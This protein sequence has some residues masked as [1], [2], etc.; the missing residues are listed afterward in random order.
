VAGPRSQRPGGRLTPERRRLLDRLLDRALDLPDDERAAFLARCRQRA[1]RLAA[2]LDRLLIA[3]T[4]PTGFIDRSA[5][6][7]A[8]EALASKVADSG[9]GESLDPGTRL[10]AWR[11][12]EAVGS[13]G[14]GE[15]YRAERAD[16]AFEMVAAVKLIRGPSDDLARLLTTERQTLARL[17]HPG[18]ARLLDGGVSEDGRPWLAMDWVD[19][20]TLDSW[21]AT[22][23]STVEACLRV[24]GEACEA[25][26]A[27]HR[28]LIVHGDIK[29][30]NIKVTGEGRVCLLDFGVARLL[31]RDNQ[32]DA[33][34]ALTPGYAAPE[35]LEGRPVST[36]A[37][38]YGL[39]A[40]L[41][42]MVHGS[43][44]GH[45]EAIEARAAFAGYR[46][47][48][49]IRAI[50]GRARQDDPALR[51]PT[52]E[53]M[54]L[55]VARLRCDLP[56]RARRPRLFERAGLWVRRH[57]VGAAFGAL[58]VV[59]LIVGVTG[60][61]WQARVAAIE[62]DLA[63]A[64][65][66]RSNAL[67]E[68]LTLLFREVG[69]LAE[70]GDE[71]TARELL[72]QTARV[73]DEWLADDPQLRLQIEAV[74]AEI[75]IAL[76][77]WA[78]A[79]A[80][81]ADFA[82]QDLGDNPVLRSIALLDMAQ[83]QHR[84][85][86]V[87]EGLRLAERA[88]GELDSLPGTHPARLSDA[89]QVRGRLRRDAGDWDGAVADLRRAREMALEVSSGPRPLMARAENNLATTLLIG[90]D[91]AGAARHLEAAEALWLA[92]ER[93]ES[94][95]AL[96]VT[97]NLAS[98]LDRLGRVEEAER[99]LRR[100]V[101]VR[102]ERFGPSGAMGAAR[103]ALGRI[104]VVRGQ[105]DEAERHLG[106]AAEIFARFSGEDTPD[107]AASLLGLGEFHEARGDHAV[108]L[109]HFRRSREIMTGLLGPRHPYSLR[110]RLASLRVARQL[111]D[112]VEPEGIAE[113]AADVEAAGGAA[114]SMAASLQCEMARMDVERGRPE[115]A[116]EAANRCLD[117]RRALELGGWRETE[118]AALAALAGRLASGASSDAAEAVEQLGEQMYPGHPRVRWFERWIEQRT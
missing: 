6:D 89:L 66:A 2:W 73:A 87:D 17:N 9:P 24:F 53:A 101:E 75:M 97:A 65:A 33:A 50:I 25:V 54:A 23:A 94:S 95:D 88:V 110:T 28:E 43:A 38:I 47:L 58:A 30:A 40:L 77:D 76:S 48:R 59:L 1:P 34:L 31:D 106:R 20:Q 113:L 90:G 26:A 98:V 84:K 52:V 32:N 102:E 42:W 19:G 103:L 114:R 99:R 80:L 117:I 71:L 10:G 45:N 74:L 14:M 115:A 56:I 18:I 29:P 64:E 111:E 39:G 5:S 12:V 46:R 112:E 91:L 109:D 35:L 78:S 37:D 83:V 13:G 8:G 49:D 92:L 63:Q 36:A 7:L 55:D 72:D 60:V 81:L 86:R 62:R 15:V 100:V 116:L 11:I 27:A 61:A 16:G 107:Y 108:A 105:L 41:D 51:Y 57:Q 104:L 118:A 44:P 4:E 79:E 68:H 22:D 82:E 96:A 3:S 67:R 93:G 21:C 69:S 70:D 85:G